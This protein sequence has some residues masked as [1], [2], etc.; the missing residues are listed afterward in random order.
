MRKSSFP[1]TKRTTSTH[2]LPGSSWPR[3][4]KSTPQKKLTEQDELW[5][6]L[7]LAGIGGRTVAEA[8]DRVSW[9]EF[10]AWMSYRASHGPLHLHGRLQDGFA[11]VAHTIASVAPRRQGARRPKLQDFMAWLPRAADQPIDL[12]TAMERWR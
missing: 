9:D 12:E 6:E 10:F 11:R 4:T 2:R 1:T 5:H 3:S 7:V 8:K